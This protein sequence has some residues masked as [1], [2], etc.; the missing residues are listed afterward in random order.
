MS[1]LLEMLSGLSTFLA[2]YPT[3][4]KILLSLWSIFTAVI[5]LALIFA[6]P[7]SIVMA[8]ERVEP[9]GKP[10]K[11]DSDGE[12]PPKPAPT[13]APTIIFS[14]TI[15][16]DLHPP[17]KWKQ[18]DVPAQDKD[19]KRLTV[20]VGVLWDP[21]RWAL[22][23]A[24]QIGIGEGETIPIE[25]VIKGLPRGETRPII[26]VGIASHE[27]ADDQPDVEVARAEVR[28]DRLVHLCSTHY[29]NANIHSL[30]LGFYQGRR[31][32]GGS[33]TERRVILLVV[34]SHDPGAD[35]SSGVKDALL[36]ASVDA[37][38][39]FD[40]RKYSN[41][42]K[43]TFTVKERRVLPDQEHRQKRGE[44]G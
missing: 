27:N 3:W 21:Y 8:G 37:R 35:L 1:K 31:E 9:P 42:A 16:V 29:P 23:S 26:A 12:A 15:I 25:A 17:V 39:S 41:F 38:F 20:S 22:N 33:S 2:S 13:P 44:T 36:K 10:L 43:D 24:E 11:P 5:F 34:T 4:V 30:N 18:V 6:R 40:A 14:P 32:F 28:A 7:S 19:G